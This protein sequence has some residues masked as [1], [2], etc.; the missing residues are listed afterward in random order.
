M[1]VSVG[2]IAT[3][4]SYTGI[5]YK[6]SGAWKDATTPGCLC[7]GWGAGGKDQ[8]GRQFHG[9]ADEATVY[10]GGVNNLEV[11]TRHPIAPFAV[12]IGRRKGDVGA[13]FFA[14]EAG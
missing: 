2:N 7:E 3:N 4:A 10:P 1:G 13:R 5:A 6:M 11:H 8:F 14:G 12:G 9:E